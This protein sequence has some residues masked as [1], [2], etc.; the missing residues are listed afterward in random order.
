MYEGPV[1]F[2]L[3]LYASRIHEACKIGRLIY[4]MRSLYPF[5]LVH[6]LY[7]HHEALLS[8]FLGTSL[9]FVIG[10]IFHFLIPS[11]NKAYPLLKD[12]LL[13]LCFFHLLTFWC[14][15]PLLLSVRLFVLVE[16]TWHSS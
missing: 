8:F 12:M 14:L 10:Y 7:K 6:F 4:R 9:A 13:I 2:L 3:K 5:L 1:F 11:M 15:E 16:Q